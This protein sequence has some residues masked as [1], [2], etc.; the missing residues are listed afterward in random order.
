MNLS[1]DTFA[2][3]LTDPIAARTAP[4]KQISHTANSDGGELPLVEG[5]LIKSQCNCDILDSQVRIEDPYL[6]GTASLRSMS[7]LCA[8]TF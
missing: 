5:N 2:H 7:I 4:V 8:P 3:E 6:P 1:P